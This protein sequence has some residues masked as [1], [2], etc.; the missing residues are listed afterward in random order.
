MTEY[1]KVQISEF[2]G[3]GQVVVRADTVTEAV[4]IFEELAKEAQRVT[5]ASLALKNYAKITGALV[6]EPTK[7]DTPTVK[8]SGQKS[9]A[10][11]RAGAELCDH[12]LPWTD[13]QGA[14]GKN[15]QPYAHRFYCAFKTDNWKDRCKPRD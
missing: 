10:P 4:E 11:A 14:K 5:D 2:V 8:P 15:G 9:S 7:T 13:L 6:E 12:G 1:N 3:S